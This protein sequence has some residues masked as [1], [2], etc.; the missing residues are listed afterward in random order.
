MARVHIPELND[1][2]SGKKLEPKI[3][4]ALNSWRPSMFYEESRFGQSPRCS[5]DSLPGFF[6]DRRNSVVGVTRDA[7]ALQKRTTVRKCGSQRAGPWL[8]HLATGEN[9]EKQIEIG[10][11]PSHR[12]NRS[13]K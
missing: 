8:G 9:L 1:R 7:Q 13:S 10:H 4:A 12:T 2:G 6:T 3:M 11:A 5:I